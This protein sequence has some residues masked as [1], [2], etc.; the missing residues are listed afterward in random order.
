MERFVECRQE[1]EQ[2]KLLVKNAHWKE[3]IELDRSAQAATDDWF[4]SRRGKEVG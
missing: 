2:M 4:L 1:H 3:L